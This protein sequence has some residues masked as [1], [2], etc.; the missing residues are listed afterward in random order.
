MFPQLSRYNRKTSREAAGRYLEVAR[1]H[2]LSAAQM[3]LAFVNSRHFVTSN[4]IGATT[5]QQLKEN[6]NSIEITLDNDVLRDIYAVY[7]EYPDPA[8]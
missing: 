7:Q 8:P 3:A 2:G 4:I 5:M 6:I 1:Q